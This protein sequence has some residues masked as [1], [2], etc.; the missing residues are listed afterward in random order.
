MEGEKAEVKLPCLW[1]PSAA[2]QCPHCNQRA[3]APASAP[4]ARGGGQDD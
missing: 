2:Q 4:F 1:V 3:L